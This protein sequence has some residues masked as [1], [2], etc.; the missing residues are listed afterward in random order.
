MK[1][2]LNPGRTASASGSHQRTSTYLGSRLEAPCEGVFT[3]SF[4]APDLA[5]TSSRSSSPLPITC[6]LPV[7]SPLRASNIYSGHPVAHLSA[8]LILTVNTSNYPLECSC[9]FIAYNPRATLD[10]YTYVYNDYKSVLFF[11]NCGAKL[12]GKG[13]T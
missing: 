2:Q 4:E 7:L 10:K 11:F 8:V 13:I 6:F 5:V 1:L 9:F 12:Y 3:A